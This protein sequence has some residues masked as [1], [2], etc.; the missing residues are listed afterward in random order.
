MDAMEIFN[1]MGKEV[2]FTQ[3]PYNHLFV[4]ADFQIYMR[5]KEFM[6][7][8][9]EYNAVVIQKLGGQMGRAESFAYGDWAFLFSPSR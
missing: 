1:A 4:G 5:V 9:K 6:R 2:V 8:G 3:V 7:G